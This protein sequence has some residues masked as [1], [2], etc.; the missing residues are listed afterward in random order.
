MYTF[1]TF[2]GKDGYI[3]FQT[4]PRMFD[5]ETAQILSTVVVNHFESI[6]IVQ[7]TKPCFSGHRM[8]LVTKSKAASLIGKQILYHFTQ[9]INTFKGAEGELKV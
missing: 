6:K 3:M 1:V 2:Q 4:C 7:G 8:V 9:Q 5:T